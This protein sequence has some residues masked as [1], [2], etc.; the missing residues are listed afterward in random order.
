[1]RNSSCC[2]GTQMKIKAPLSSIMDGIAEA[3]FL[4][5]RSLWLSTWKTK[6]KK[7]LNTWKWINFTRELILMNVKNILILSNFIL[8]LLFFCFRLLLKGGEWGIKIYRDYLLLLV[9][10]FSQMPNLPI[11]HKYSIS[12]IS[13]P[14]K[15]ILRYNFV[16]FNVLIHIWL[17]F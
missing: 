11:S 6:T 5:P 16:L 13:L 8:F 14:Q 15:I 7:T 10:C 9:L 1:M 3:Y 2:P 17:L 4:N 12:S